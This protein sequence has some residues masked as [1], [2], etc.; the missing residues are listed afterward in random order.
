M[1]GGLSDARC[2]RARRKLAGLTCQPGGVRCLTRSRWLFDHKMEEA[3]PERGRPAASSTA[4]GWWC[5]MTKT[6]PATWRGTWWRCSPV[7]CSPVWPPVGAESGVE[8]GRLRPAGYRRAGGCRCLRAEC[9]VM[10]E[11]VSLDAAGRRLGVSGGDIR[12]AGY[13]KVT[14]DRLKAWEHQPPAWLRKARA[15]KRRPAMRRAE[16][17][18]RVCG[19]VREVRPSLVADYTHLVCSPCSR[20]GKRPEVP[21]RPGMILVCSVNVAG[22][23]DGYIHRIATA[24][25]RASVHRAAALARAAFL[26]APAVPES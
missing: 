19:T 17:S 12:R 5:S 10:G 14:A 1:P 18:C 16:V 11:R 23:F 20:S 9:G 3:L 6:W 26:G 13:T 15:R 8:G 21:S 25:E 2:D 4:G 7:L 24:Q 22:Y